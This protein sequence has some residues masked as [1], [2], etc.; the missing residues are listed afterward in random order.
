MATKTYTTLAPDNLYPYLAA[1]ARVY[2]T[3]RQSFLDR[4]MA[5]EDATELVKEFQEAYKLNKRQV[6][7]IRIEVKAAISASLKCRQRHIKIIEG[8]LK[9]VRAEIKTLEKKLNKGSFDDAC[10]LKTR[11]T[12]IE[13][14]HFALHQKKRRAYL[15]ENKLRHLKDKPLI[16]NIPNSGT[17]FF[18]MGSRDE[19]AGNQVCQLNTDGRIKIRVPAALSEQFGDYVYADCLTLSYGQQEIN[20]ALNN[21]NGQAVTFRF[22]CRDFIW[23]V[24]VSVDV[25]EVPTQSKPRWENGCI[26]VDLNPGVIGWAYVNVEGNLHFLGQFRLNLH[27]KRSTQTEAILSDI[28]AQ[29]GLV[30]ESLECPIVIEDLDFSAKKNQLRERGRQ[31]ARMLSGFAYSKW[32]EVLERH[33]GNRGIELI[34]VN[35]AYSSLIGLVKF[36]KRYGLSSD[37]A[38]AMALARRAMRLSERVPAKSAYLFDNGKH[39][40]SHWH[41]LHKELKRFRRHSFYQTGANSPLELILP[42][43]VSARSGKKHKRGSRAG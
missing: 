29:L 43:L 26:G 17:D 4:V 37:T 13:N 16:V 11:R 6:N 14:K 31:Y 19:T 10:D 20:A 5:G 39:V 27:S 36:V 2:N 23:Y 32:Q 3:A 30:A 21:P 38:A 1:Y 22:Y 15:L 40:W 42:N 12:V 18:M 8:Q 34:K 35:P 7:S 25:A 24:A 28:A 9:S 41:E 33:C